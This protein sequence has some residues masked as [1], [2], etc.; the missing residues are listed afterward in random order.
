M[1]GGNKMRL[2]NDLIRDLMIFSEN[3]LNAV[4]EYIRYPEIESFA[5]NKNRSI[6]EINYHLWELNNAGLLEVRF[7]Y[8][9]DTI[10][11]VVINNMTWEG[12]QFL[13]KIRD[14]RIWKDTK[15]VASK[16]ESISV[17]MLSE[18][19]TNVLNHFIDKQM[20]Y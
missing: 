10:I 14:P 5:E 20:G 12:H 15:K 9:S 1:K 3:S 17:T 13:D 7:D 19:G 4:T 6:D 11:Y 18:I 2:D 8:G 16:L